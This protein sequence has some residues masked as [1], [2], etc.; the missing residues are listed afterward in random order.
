MIVALWDRVKLA[1]D[2]GV[3]DPGGSVGLHAGS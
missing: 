3:T 2:S 1:E